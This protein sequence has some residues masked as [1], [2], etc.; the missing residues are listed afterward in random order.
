MKNNYRH[1][2]LC[3]GIMQREITAI[4]PEL[5]QKYGEIDVTYLDPGLH[6]NLDK[7]STALSQKCMEIKQ[8][9]D[10]ITLVFGSK[11]HPDLDQLAK[12]CGMDMMKPQDCISFL[13]GTQR[14]LL[15]KECK[16]FYL[17]PGWLEYWPRIFKEGLGWDSIDARQNLGFY[18]RILLLDPGVETFSDEQIL[19]FYEYCQVPIEILP[20]KLDYLKQNLIDAL[21]R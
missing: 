2:L 12:T 20:V 1:S 19:E 11:C 18:D 4:L 8:T 9:C 13:T 10:K 5:V 17:S 14:D 6:V 3:C 16:T 21:A 7:L 15:D